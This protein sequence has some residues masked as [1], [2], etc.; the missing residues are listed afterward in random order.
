MKLNINWIISFGIAIVLTVNFAAPAL[1]VLSE[2]DA[3]IYGQTEYGGVLV[4]AQD[5]QF[6]IV[7]KRGS[8]E[9]ARYRYGDSSSAGN[10]YL[11]HLSMDALGSQPTGT[12]RVGDSIDIYLIAGLDEQLLATTTMAE[13]GSFTELDLGANIASVKDSDNDGHVDAADN[14][15]QIVNPEQID[16]DGDGVGDLCD[17]FPT[18]ADEWADSDG[19]GI[20]DNFDHTPHGFTAPSAD[21]NGNGIAD[22]EEFNNRFASE[23][24][25]IDEDVPLPLWA[26]LA[27]GALLA[28]I[29]SRAVGKRDMRRGHK[30]STT[31]GRS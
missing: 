20:G 23:P 6:E 25:A 24:P 22:L 4:T 9:L 11:L 2:P 19:D 29:G 1:A 31:G 15:V 28:R 27:L 18:A 17:A 26:L 7:A 16:T 5:S 12:V 10:Y 14:C 13:R 8:E 21:E 3:V 30:S